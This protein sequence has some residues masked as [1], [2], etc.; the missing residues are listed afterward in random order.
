MKKINAGD[1]VAKCPF[2][3]A[4]PAVI[5]E[6]KTDSNNKKHETFLIRCEVNGG[7]STAHY[8]TLFECEQAWDNKI[9]AIEAQRI[10]LGR[11]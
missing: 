4:H 5:T 3:N 10:M 7:L 11:G 9:N 6:E 2:C 1:T 8:D